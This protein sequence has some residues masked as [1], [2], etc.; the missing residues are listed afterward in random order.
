MLKSWRGKICMCDIWKTNFIL[1]L[2]LPSFPPPSLFCPFLFLPS[3]YSLFCHQNKLS[4][5]IFKNT[6]HHSMLHCVTRANRLIE[7]ELLGSLGHA[8]KHQEVRQR[9]CAPPGIRT[10]L[11]H[12]GDTQR[13][14]R[15]VH[16]ARFWRASLA[17]LQDHRCAPLLRGALAAP[18][19]HSARG[20]PYYGERCERCPPIRRKGETREIKCR[21]FYK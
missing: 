13:V 9:R 7:L 20:I 17:A 5:E 3:F 18:L 6:Y 12:N 1:C 14:E 16:S 8:A 19:G 21:A 2:V 15:T 11:R 4:V 10:P